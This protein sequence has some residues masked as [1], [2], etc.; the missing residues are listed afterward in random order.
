MPERDKQQLMARQHKPLRTKAKTTRS[1]AKPLTIAEPPSQYV[2]EEKHTFGGSWTNQKL[3][4]V[5]KYLSAYTTALKHQP[6]QLAY[7]DAFAGTGYRT[8]KAVDETT[9]LMFPE[10]AEKET[11]QFIEGSARVA[12]QTLPRFLKYIFIE[13]RGKHIPELEK[14]KEEFP[15]I[16]DDI[17]IINAEAN[18]YL[19][20][21]CKKN[22]KKHRAVIFLDPYGM[23]VN[24]NTLEAIARTE[25]IDLWILFPLGVAVNRLLKRDG[26]INYA[27]KKRLDE[28]FG[29][30]DWYETFYKEITAEDL[31]GTQTKVRKVSGFTMI[32]SYFVER[33]KTIFPGVAENPL[34]LYNSKGNPLYLLCFAASNPKGAKPALRI[35]QDILRR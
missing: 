35:A 3:E 14:L 23:Q 7:I 20:K 18:E 32:S 15:E 19:K 8:L 25:A 29:T 10:L 2:S 4:R 33:L 27:V 1:R 5:K 30:Q 17:S 28:M 22:W 16:A 12:L 24:W 31:F 21:L 34:P 13:K 9:E 6:F 11:Q 26:N